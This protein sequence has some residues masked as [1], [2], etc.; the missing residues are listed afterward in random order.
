MANFLLDYSDKQATSFGGMS[1]TKRFID[2]TGIRKYM[3]ELDLP[4]L[5]SNRGYS[6]EQIIESFWLGIWTGVLHYIHCDWF[7][8]DKTLHFSFGWDQMPSQSTY[9][10]FFVSSP[11]LLI[12]RF[13]HN[14]SIG[15]YTQ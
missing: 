2:Q 11:K 8:Y 12:Q 15:F 1:L 7:R 13:F 6:A 10:R 5:G 4:P 3:A 9:S 14:G